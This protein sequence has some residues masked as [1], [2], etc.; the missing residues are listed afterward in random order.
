MFKKKKTNNVIK[1]IDNS[2]KNIETTNSTNNE[3]IFIN[4]SPKEHSLSVHPKR[5][6]KK[7]ILFTDAEN[8]EFSVLKPKKFLNLDDMKL[9][10]YL[11]EKDI[12]QN[13]PSD[14][15]PDIDTNENIPEV[16]K[17]SSYKNNSNFIFPYDS[18]D[19]QRFE[20]IPKGPLTGLQY[21]KDLENEISA[22][23]KTVSDE[24]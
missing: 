15:Q 2:A 18:E 3:Q 19:L 17:N 13:E 12:K 6:L 16:D 9:E 11:E 23:L 10:D 1:L 7:K 8:E 22:K 24:N 21:L 5:T 14:I 20:H 4:D